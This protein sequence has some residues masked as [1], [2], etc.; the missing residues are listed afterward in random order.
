ML[1]ILNKNQETVGVASNSNP[2][3]LPYF[4]DWHTENLEGIN[5]YE[6]KVPSDHADSG[7]LEV[8]GHVIV[9]NLDGEHLLFT[10]KE[11]S[12]GN[13]S[14]RRVKSIFCEETAISELLT[15]VQ[16]PETFS[17]ATL[18]VV[19]RSVI[20]NTLEYTL[21]DVPYTESQDVEFSDYM[22]VL[23]ALRQVVNQFGMEMY[24]TVQLQGTKIVKKFINIVKERGQ[25]TGVRFDYSYDLRGVGRTEDSSQVITALIG[26]GKG[27][28]SQ[29][30]INL[31]SVSAFNDGDIYKE[32]G[33]DWIGSEV[34]L[35]RFGRNGRHRFGF[36]VDDK[37]ESDNELKN[38]TIKELKKRS[39]P[40]VNYSC[41]I[42]TLERL[43]G[44]S[45]K[46][47]RIGDTI[48]VNDKSFTPYIVINGRVKQIKRSYTRN[49]VDEIELGNYKPITLSP[50]K[51][52]KDL[53]N[54]ISKNEAKWNNTSIQIVIESLGGTVFVN[55][56]G[57]TTL[58]AKLYNNEDEI[59]VE[60]KEFIY[61]WYK[62]TASGIEVPLWGGTTNYR[63]GK[64]QRIT[65][66]DLE[67]QATFKVTIEKR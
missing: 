27:D 55:G 61:K 43:T 45:A 63:V 42:T 17:S 67:R 56:Q 26:V 18:E 31:T 50:N 34:A 3:S 25:K 58:V 11:I 39:V 65:P 47:I 64:T 22:T 15:D 48:V 10:I 2:L 33:A 14:G 12:E 24:F 9:R 60:G 7:K 41:S 36:F 40:A 19:V 1:F 30:R 46:K 62:Y 13:D 28:N 57:E 49:N 44:Y 29:T 54:I 5:T 6:F 53:Q 51:S 32:S 16:R 4:E 21:N 23:E 59:D 66:L 35:Q 38:R 8:E 37:S 52:I 20:G